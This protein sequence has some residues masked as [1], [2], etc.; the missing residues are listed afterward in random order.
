MCRKIDVIVFPRVEEID[1][2]SIK[3]LS[4]AGQRKQ[5]SNVDACHVRQLLR[6]ASYTRSFN[7]LLQGHHP[8]ACPLS[9]A[10]GSINDGLMVYLQGIR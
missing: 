10:F 5:R 3:T 4:H 7:K 2:Y 1:K 6:H 9:N 8:D